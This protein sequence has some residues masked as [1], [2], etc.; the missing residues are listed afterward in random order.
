[1]ITPV[2]VIRLAL[3]GTVSLTVLAGCGGEQ[4]S[5]ADMCARTTAAPNDTITFTV[6]HTTDHEG[7]D[8]DKG[9]S[10][11]HVRGVVVQADP[12]NTE[13]I[14]VSI[15]AADDSVLATIDDVAPGAACGIDH[16]FAPGD[17]WLRTSDGHAT[18]FSS[19]E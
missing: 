19:F 12:D 1:M 10:F 6:T 5:A 3:A 14:S 15:V 8:T 2:T 4:D 18:Q 9:S 16:D 17:Y 7:F 11:S 13:A